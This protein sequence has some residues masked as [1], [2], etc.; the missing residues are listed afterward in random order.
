MD[1]LSKARDTQLN[2]IQKKT[3]KNI[4]ELRKIIQ[5]SGLIKHGELRSMLIEKFNLGFGDASMLVHFA[6]GTDGQT[7]A[8]TSNASIED[9]VAEIYSGPKANFRELHDHIMNIIHSF[10]DFDITP[11][12]GYLSLRRK[13]QFVMIGPATNTR[14]ELG[15]NVK[16]LGENVRLKAQPKGS[17]CDY[18]ILVNTVDEVDQQLITWMKTAYEN[19]G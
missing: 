15:L 18:K 16:D 19:A 10:G 13:R 11:K 9:L 5:E 14:F 2:N 6:L 12:K 4:E 8:E 1:S 17:M 7:A 3:G